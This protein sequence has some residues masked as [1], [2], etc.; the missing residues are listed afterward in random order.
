MAYKLFLDDIRQPID[1]FSYMHGR[2]GKSVHIYLEKDWVVVKN[3][4]QFIA[5][6]DKNG[7]PELI[8]FDHDLADGHYHKN[9]QE[10]M[11][12]YDSSDFHDDDLNKTGYHCAVFLKGRC[13]ELNT[14]LPKCIVHSMNP[15]GVQNINRLLGMAA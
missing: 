12:N 8:S 6:I 14:P 13:A 2:I 1:C 10:G 3:Y 9:M 15:V 7:L 5:C 4:P 11:L